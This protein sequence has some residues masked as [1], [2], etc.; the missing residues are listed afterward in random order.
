MVRR[1][2]GIALVAFVA[3]ATAGARADLRKDAPAVVCAYL[4]DAG[5]GAGEYHK[6][7]RD[8]YFASSPE[9]R[10][11]AGEPASHLQYNVDG[12]QPSSVTKVYLNLT[13]NS[14]ADA[15]AGHAALLD[16]GA[17]L[18]E[19]AT[20]KPL[21]EKARRSIEGEKGGEWKVGGATVRV[22]KIDLPGGKG[23]ILQL[24]IE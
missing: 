18:V 8:H 5:L 7:G 21:P 19:R 2:V 3:L 14:E 9:K 11:G 15:K 13:V 16:A 4:K 6:I 1:P 23:Y 20:G 12:R 10:V 24:L 17:T 22:T